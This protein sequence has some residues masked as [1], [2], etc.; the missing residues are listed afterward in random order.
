MG[1]PLTAF[2]PSDALEYTVISLGASARAERV[3]RTL[4]ISY[5]EELKLTYQWARQ[6]GAFGKAAQIQQR[7]QQDCRGYQ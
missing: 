4:G 1:S 3:A 2:Q 6:G 5:C 7:R